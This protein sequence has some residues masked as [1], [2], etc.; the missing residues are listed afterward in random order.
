[1]A[2]IRLICKP[3]NHL[4]SIFLHLK[5]GLWH[6][7]YKNYFKGFEL[8]SFVPLLKQTYQNKTMKNRFFYK[9]LLLLSGLFLGSI[10]NL[11][12]QSV[13]I[14]ITNPEPSAALDITSNSKGLLIPRL[15]SYERNTMASP[16]KGLMVFD[17]ITNSFWFYNGTAWAEVGNF[18]LPYLGSST[19]NDEVFS[20]TNTGTG[21]AIS[22]TSSGNSAAAIEGNSSAA[23]SGYGVLGTSSSATGFGVSGINA[24]G[25]AVY[26]FSGGNGTAL[27]GV[28]SSGYGLVSSGNLRLTGGNTNPS[29]GAVLTSVDDSGNAVWKPH[30]IAFAASA[31]QNQSITNNTHRKIEFATESYDFGDGF[32]PFTGTTTTATSVFTAPVA[33]IYHFSAGMNFYIVSSVYN[34]EYA[35]IKLYKNDSSIATVFGTMAKNGATSSSNGTLSKDISLAAGDKIHV[36]VYQRNDGGLS[37]ISNNG[38]RDDYCWFTGHLIVAN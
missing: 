3:T 22:A 15:T 8:F 19:S 34:I 29:A 37:A 13:G 4:K 10:L 27:R 30:K 16:A 18:R 33:G 12:G 11:N 17:F 6:R 31:A 38:N 24:T 25:T 2:E 9:S 36:V 5:L 32:L 21:T 26:G 14:N 23:V 7:L 20:I 1:M 28:S 35:E